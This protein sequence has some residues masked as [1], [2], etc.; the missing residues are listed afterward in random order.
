MKLLNSV[1]QKYNIDT[2]YQGCSLI[3]IVIY[4]YKYIILP[5]FGIIRQNKT[6]V[7]I[8][9]I[10]S[11]AIPSKEVQ[12]KKTRRVTLK[13]MVLGIKFVF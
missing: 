13:G 11:H 8:E 12:L 4:F 3:A 9:N 7:S 2:K 1:E 6:C 5:L 10:V